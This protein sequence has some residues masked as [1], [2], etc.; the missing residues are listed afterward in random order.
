VEAAPYRGGNFLA[1]MSLPFRGWTATDRPLGPGEVT[2]PP[3]ASLLSQ[4]RS[5]AGE[6]VQLAV[7]AGHRQDTI[8][9]PAICMSGAGWELLDRQPYTLQI[10]NRQIPATR[11]LLAK[12][13]QHLITT[14]FFT[15][16][17]HAS[18]NLIRFQL[19]QL[20]ERL[21][22]RVPVGALVR[23]LVPAGADP[24]AASRTGD[25]FAKATLPAVLER[26]R[27]AHLA[28]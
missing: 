18:G 27:G 17:D 28:R 11:A 16:G 4:Y 23:I 14:Y 9:T 24:A 1:G 10:G 15:D 26:L 12:D 6:T 7:V 22:G 5:P 21:R 19:S 8:H 25:A 20:L 2:P 3:D 13:R